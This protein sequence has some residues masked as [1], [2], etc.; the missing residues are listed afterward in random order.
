MKKEGKRKQKKN[1]RK[2]D[3]EKKKKRESKV[4]NLKRKRLVVISFT[5]L[6]I[7]CMLVDMHMLYAIF[8]LDFIN[9]L[10]AIM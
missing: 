4:K 1:K 5:T 10:N 7:Q 8:C 6:S 3:N 2:K 9:Y